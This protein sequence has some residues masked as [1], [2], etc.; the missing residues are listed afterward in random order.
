MNKTQKNVLVAVVMGLALFFFLPEANGLT[1][2]GICMLSVFIPTIYL[3]LTCGTSW[4]SLLSVTIVVLLGIYDGSSAYNTLWG[5]IC[6]AAVIPFL[7]VASVL[8]E[9][10]AFEWIVKWIISRKFIHGRPNLFMLMLILAMVVI[11]IFTAPQVVSVL[12]F[13]LLGDVSTAIGY[14]KEEKFYQS[15]GLL[16]GWIAQIC[17]GI[18]IWGRPYI[19]TMVA[20][21]VGL[22]FTDFTAM[23][24]FKFAGIYL[25]IVIIVAFLILKLWMK[26]DVGKFK[27]FDDAKM[28]EDLKANPIS[29]QGKI[30][31]VG[32]LAIL[33]CYVLAYLDFL[34]PIQEYFSGITIAASVTFV[35][36]LLC[37]ITVDGKPVM[38]FNKAAAKVPWSM[39]I[40][41]GAIMFYAGAVGNEAYGISACLQNILGPIVQN[42]PSTVAILIGLTFACVCTNFCSNSV[43]GV[44]VCSSF[45][46]ALM[47]IEGLSQSSILAFACGVIAICGTAICT[48]SACP[49]MSIVYSDLGVEYKGTA[50][51]SAALCAIM[52][53]ITTFVLV[54]LGSILF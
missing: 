18:L 14:K 41:L 43:S 44:V 8:E 5:N 49:T 47:G 46:P 37:L 48:V 50:K 27:D 32:M 36:A 22:G 40:F 31:L 2:A 42:L 21:V 29:K 45:I 39:I 6:A 4:T 52:V 11:S 3:W 15:Q 17:D 13:K 30:A 12:F 28:R 16:V 7:M 25:I 38:D 9:S 24:Y 20:V 34:G 51:Y 35:C 1:Q 54:P 10:G 33:V 26:P 53:L 19:L 23:Q